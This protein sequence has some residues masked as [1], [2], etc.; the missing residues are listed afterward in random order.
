MQA[1][2]IRI[3]GVLAMALLTVGPAHSTG[4]EGPSGDSEF[5]R[6]QQR[7]PCLFYRSQAWNRDL[8]HYSRDMLWSC[9]AIE[10]RRRAGM[11]LSDRLQAAEFALMTYRSRVI[12]MALEKFR[13]EETFGADTFHREVSETEKWAIAE[14]TGAL[15]AME[16]LNHGF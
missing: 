6:A 11:Q 4:L 16:A 8:A 7:D 9:E 14:E 5:G 2:F 13:Q 1:F 3:F 10:Q 12:A 15:A